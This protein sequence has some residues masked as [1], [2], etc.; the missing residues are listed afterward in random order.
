MNRKTL[1]WFLL[2]LIFASALRFYNPIF[3]SLWGDETHS[4]YLAQ[5]VSSDPIGLATLNLIKDSHLPVYFILLSAWTKLFGVGEY[6]LRLLSILI[7]LSSIIAFFFFARKIFD[8]KTALVSMLL[9]AIS[10]LAL[11]H[12][13]EI[14]MYGLLLLLSILSSFY[15]W[16]LV[17]GKRN[18]LVSTAYFVASFLLVMTHIYGSLIIAAQFIYLVFS[19]W[20]EKKTSTFLHILTLQILVGALALPAYIA[21]LFVNFSAVISGTSDMAFSVFPWYLKLPLVFFVLSLGETVAPWNLMIVLPAAIVFGFLFLWN[22]KRLPDKRIVYLLILCLFPILFSVLFLAP[23]MPKF[24]I[25]TLPF[26]L[27]LIGYSIVRVKK[28]SL[29]CGVILVIILLQAYSIHNYFNLVSYHNS[30]QIE[31][32][33]DVATSIKEQYRKGDSILSSNHFVVYRLLNYY[34]NITGHVNAP[35]FDLEEV[36]INLADEKPERIW[37][38]TNIHDDRAFPPGYI[39]RIKAALEENYTLKN[40]QKYIPYEETL[41]SKLP[42]KRHQPGSYRVRVRLY[43]KIR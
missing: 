40:E 29:R 22:L 17:S 11:M 15:F 9:L 24:L 41:V 23:T 33:R 25:I 20:Q 30:N 14:R 7:G 10:P 34:L 35:I 4:F 43:K 36:K 42:I 37:F 32:W 12:S 1:I 5:E 13:Q 16:N 8:D 3:R 39:D 6:I 2:I 38:V 18:L 28:V 27:L 21:M 26:Y 31:P 19:L